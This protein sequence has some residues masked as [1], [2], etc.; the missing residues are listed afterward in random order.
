M[1][2]RAG[3]ALSVSAGAVWPGRALAVEV[4]FGGPTPSLLNSLYLITGGRLCGGNLVIHAAVGATALS[5]L[6]TGVNNTGIGLNAQPS[7]ATVSNT[8]TLG[9]SS[10]ATLRCQVTTITALSASRNCS[11]RSVRTC[12][13]RPA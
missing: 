12:L 6:T 2:V 10:I 13:S 9:N 3:A 11:S 8:I 1:F 5:T 4:D 7:T